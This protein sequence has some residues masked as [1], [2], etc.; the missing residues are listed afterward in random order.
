MPSIINNM[1]P[2]IK[3]RLISHFL[4]RKNISCDGPPAFW[5]SWPAISNSGQFKLGKWC[6]F[7]SYSLRQHIKVDVGAVLEVGSHSFINDG[8][9]I[10]VAKR[11]AIGRD[12]RI[13]PN[14]HIIDTNF[15]QVSPHE[16]VKVAPVFIGD[17]VWIGTGAMI[18]P[19]SRIGDHSVIGAGSVVSGE[20][21]DRCVAVGVPAR[22]VRTFEAADDWRRM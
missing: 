6:S 7:M 20:I 5:G 14:V 21:P 19:G 22:V 15:H 11:I 9:N 3:I 12:A 18:L 1:L 17:N 10:Y 16:L 2:R 13:G 8:V 4:K